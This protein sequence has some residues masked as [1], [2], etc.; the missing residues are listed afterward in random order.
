MTRA[1]KSTSRKAGGAAK[2]RKPAKPAKARKPAKPA[3]ARKPAKPAKPAKASKPAK[4]RK[5]P[6]VKRTLKHIE[7][8]ETFPRTECNEFFETSSVEKLQSVFDES[9][10][11]DLVNVLLDLKKATVKR[12]FELLGSSRKR[13]VAETAALYYY[14]EYLTNPLPLQVETG[15]GET[16]PNYYA[17]LGVPR[18]VSEDDLKTAY[19]LL[20]R[21]HSPESF[22]PTMRKAGGDGLAGIL[23]AYSNLKTPQKR[24]EADGLLPNI[25]YLYPRR[26]QSWLEAVQRVLG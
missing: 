2:A 3:K 8:L 24:H 21:A 17:I 14:K 12:F 9:Y 4:A 10:A 18:G 13:A 16:V 23:D 19:K 22:S 6:R 15:S 5:T 11:A 25:N 20:V 7:L 26:D 1:T